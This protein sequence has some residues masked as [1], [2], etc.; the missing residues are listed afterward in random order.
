MM[1]C[2]LYQ[3]E[4]VTSVFTPSGAVTKEVDW[5]CQIASGGKYMC[6]RD[7]NGSLSCVCNMM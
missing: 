4:G 5:S 2:V 6:Y 3:V 1:I 7:N